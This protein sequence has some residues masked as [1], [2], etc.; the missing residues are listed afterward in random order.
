MSA[1]FD[2]LEAIN[3]AIDTDA[4]ERAVEAAKRSVKKIPGLIDTEKDDDALEAYSEQ[5]GAWVYDIRRL[6]AAT[7]KKEQKKLRKLLLSLI[8]VVALRNQVKTETKEEFIEEINRCKNAKALAML[9]SG[10]S[11]YHFSAR[12]KDDVKKT[13]RIVIPT[14]K[15]RATRTQMTQDEFLL[16]YNQRNDYLRKKKIADR[17]A[18]G[19]NAVLSILGVGLICGIA[20]MAIL[21]V[22][23]LAAFIPVLIVFS[24]LGGYVEGFVYHGYVQKFCRN[25]VRGF[26]ETIENNVLNR[27]LGKKKWMTLKPQERKAHLA[28][29]RTEII[30]KKSLAIAAIPIGIAAGVGFAGLAFSQLVGLLSVV[31]VTAGIVTVAAPWAL[32]VIV[33]PLY[34]MVMYSMIHRAIKNNVF[35]EMKKNAIAL[36]KRKAGQS[37][38]A[39]VALCALKL[40]GLAAILAISVAAT[41]FTAGAW[42]ESSVS[43]FAAAVGLVDL[44]AN[45]IGWVIGA[46]F[47]ATGLWFSIEKGLETAKSML[48]FSLH[49]IKK[50]FSSPKNFFKACLN[51]IPFIIHVVGT[52]AVAALGTDAVGELPK[53]IG[54]TWAKITVTMVGTAEEVLVDLKDYS[55]GH[56]HEKGG[57]CDHSHGDV[58]SDVVSV[59][60]GIGGFFSRHFGKKKEKVVEEPVDILPKLTQ[61]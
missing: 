26:L 35:I 22:M 3:T 60:K 51:F 57:H 28:K 46:V 41:V 49:S 18:L 13:F 8:D 21:P 31:G 29:H 12:D 36:F 43:F 45:K 58:A 24:L 2:Q 30:I 53:V 59:F 32:A 39:H 42:L 47:L 4:R 23:P 37:M 16:I 17:V 56:K 7:K 54:N 10:K 50:V 5:Y 14:L 1:F 44:I 6:A 33:G 34:A 40:L 61:M 48:D 27:E 20:I 9:S 38:A 19:L 52:G 15:D 11:S 55:G 25:A